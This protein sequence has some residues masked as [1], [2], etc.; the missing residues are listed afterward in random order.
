[1]FTFLLNLCKSSHRLFFIGWWPCWLLL[2]GC[3]ASW[4]KYIE[5]YD[6]IAV[7]RCDAKCGEDYSAK[8]CIKHLIINSHSLIY[9]TFSILE[10]INENCNSLLLAHSLFIYLHYLIFFWMITL[11]SHLHVTSHVCHPLHTLEKLGIVRLLILFNR[12]TRGPSHFQ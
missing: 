3:L 2:S 8:V 5:D 7:A 1:M 10:M 9:L 11:P 12:V 4:T 6:S